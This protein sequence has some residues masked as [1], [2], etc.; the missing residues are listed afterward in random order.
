MRGTRRHRSLA[1]TFTLHARSHT[2]THIFTCAH[3][4]TNFRQERAH[5]TRIAHGHPSWFQG[6]F[7]AAQVVEHRAADLEARAKK[8]DDQSDSFE[9]R[10]RS[11]DVWQSKTTDE[12]VYLQNEHKKTSMHV[13]TTSRA[14]DAACS[15]LHGLCCDL[16]VTNDNMGKMGQLGFP[17]LGL[18]SSCSCCSVFTI[19]LFCGRLAGRTAKV[20]SSS[21]QRPHNHHRDRVC[22]TDSTT[23]ADVV[24]QTNGSGKKK[25]TAVELRQVTVDFVRFYP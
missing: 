4:H 1:P 10:L 6:T 13:Q 25:R 5:R 17:K 22:L 16:E 8:T 19:S 24:T 21:S 23:N 3:R 20:T 7:V 12:V 14:L 18:F 11:L 9:K 2:T 15:K